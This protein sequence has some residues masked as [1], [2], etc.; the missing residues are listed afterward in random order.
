MLY[1]YRIWHPR[2]PPEAQGKISMKMIAVS[3][4]RHLMCEFPHHPIN[5]QV[6]YKNTATKNGFYS[7]L[8]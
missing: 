1:F 3:Y 7:Q 5:I 4:S 8:T 2:V 6:D